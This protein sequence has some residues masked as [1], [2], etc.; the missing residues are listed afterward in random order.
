MNEYEID[1]VQIAKILKEETMKIVD[2]A[3]ETGCIYS[4]RKAITGEECVSEEEEEE[5]MLKDKMLKQN[6]IKMKLKL[7]L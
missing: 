7:P 6:Q 2:F 3:R 5:I 1:V 4:N